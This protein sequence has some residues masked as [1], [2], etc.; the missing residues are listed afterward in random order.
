MDMKVTNAA[1]TRG[2]AMSAVVAMRAKDTPAE[3]ITGA[4]A[5]TAATPEAEMDSMAEAV[6]VITEAGDHMP[7]AVRAAVADT[8]K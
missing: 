2:A 5:L 3:A 6:E 8:G 4:V 7:V 1:A